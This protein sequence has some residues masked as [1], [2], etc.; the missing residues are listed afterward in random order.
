MTVTEAE[1]LDATLKR[2]R[3]AGETRQNLFKPEDAIAFRVD[4]NTFRYYAPSY[5]NSEK[6]IWEAVIHLYGS[7]PGSNWAAGLKEGD[8][9]RVHRSANALRL[10]KEQQYHFFIG[11][12]S[13]LGLFSRLGSEVLEK[14]LDYLCLLELDEAHHHWLRLVG[15]EADVVGRSGKK[16]GTEAVRSL[17][18]MQG[19]VW[20]VWKRAM[21][22]LAGGAAT[23][24]ACRQTLIARGVPTSR[25]LSQP[26]WGEYKPTDF[27]GSKA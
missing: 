14:E 16:T 8:T 21:F 25:I 13:S 22:Y 3:F 7:G 1:Y 17:R 27:D 5:S 2:I 24:Q 23:I 12:E 9:A 6:G 20:D 11:D 15:I 10:R 19:N 4:H 18:D 26:F